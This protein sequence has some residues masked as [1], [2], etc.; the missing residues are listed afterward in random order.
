MRIMVKM[1]LN[2]YL[3]RCGVASRRKSENL[4]ER[5][6]V[7]V[8]GVIEKKPYRIID[9]D[10]DVVMVG[11]EE[12]W[13]PEKIYI[14]MNKPPGVITTVS[15]EWGRET[16]I[17]HLRGEMGEL[18]E[19]LI[20]SI[21]P[22]GRLDKDTTGL[23]ILTNDGDFCQKVIHP[24][25]EIHKKYEVFLD[26]ELTEMELNRVRVGEVV[27]DNRAVEPVSINYLSR[28]KDCIKYEI[29]IVEGR[30]RIIKRLFGNLGKDVVKLKRVAIGGLQLGE[31]PV[32]KCCR[33]NE[34][35][36]D[37]IFNE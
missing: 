1:R 4:L 24:S 17:S 34:E 2:K 14:M 9:T 11:D 30:K 18:D 36:K 6:I 8:N 10:E 32:G 25:E 28:M 33:I 22:V 27:V 13:L 37:K 16:V 3:A 12:I 5:G 21:F 23:L 19:Q 31:L 26:G 20:E 35:E 7:K 29:T 15:D